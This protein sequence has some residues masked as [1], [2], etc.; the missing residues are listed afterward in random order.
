MEALLKH[1]VLILSAWVPTAILLTIV[2]EAHGR[3]WLASTPRRLP[4]QFCCPGSLRTLYSRCF[5]TVIIVALTINI[6][7]G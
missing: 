2:F 1:T 3:T 6:V 4:E 7:A 5:F